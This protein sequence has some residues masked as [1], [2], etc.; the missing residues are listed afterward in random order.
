MARAAL[1]PS[2]AKGRNAQSFEPLGGLVAW[3]QNTERSPH[4]AGV[5]PWQDVPEIYGPARWDQMITD[6]DDVE[7][8]SSTLRTHE[9]S[10]ILSKQA[11]QGERSGA[12]S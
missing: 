5:E 10:C 1:S 2:D 8:P 11:F 12:A 6:M 9:D 7:W 3:L 4:P